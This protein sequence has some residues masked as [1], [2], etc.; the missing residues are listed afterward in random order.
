MKPYRGLYNKTASDPWKI[1]RSKID[2]FIQ[3]PR[4]FWLE[5]RKGIK[6]PSMPPF[7]INSTIDALFKKEF[8]VF[9]EKGEPHGLQTEFGVNAIP[10]QHEKIDI[11][12]ENFQGIQ[13]HHQPTN[14]YVFGAIDDLWINPAE[15]YIVVDYKATA[16]NKKIDKLDDTKWHD[17][18]RRQM[19]V[20]QWLLR[21][22]GLKVSDTGY[23]VYAN[24]RGDVDSFDGKVEFDIQVFPYTGK[25][26]WVEPTLTDIKKTLDSD[27]IPEVGRECEHC[28]YAKS[29]TELTISALQE[30]KTNEQSQ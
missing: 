6:R 18:Y 24:G 11:W 22:N 5:A 10:A 21:Q 25:D 26:D 29:R 17:Q 2:L 14:L 28:A 4:C 8:D 15:E 19:E 3:C 12:R 13:Y 27:D 16:K 9:R 30:R 1:S 23:F 7:L 20:Y